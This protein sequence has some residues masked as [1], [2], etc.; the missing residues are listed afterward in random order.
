MSQ[1]ETQKVDEKPAASPVEAANASANSFTAK[2]VKVVLGVQTWTIIG[3]IAIAL[4]LGAL[5]VAFS[6]EEVITALGYVFAQPSDFFT[7]FG[8]SISTFFYSLFVGAIFDPTGSG[9]AALFPITETLTNS[10]PLIL[11][12]LSVGVAFRAGL[13]NIGAQGQLMMGALVG[14]VMGFVLQLPPVIHLLFCMIMAIVGGFIWGA[15]P[16]IL[17]A[18]T[19]ANEVIVTIMLNTVASLL[20]G[21]FMTWPSLIKGT[22][23]SRSKE[24]LETSLYPEILPFI[25]NSRLHFGFIVALLAAVFVWWL[26]ERSTFGFELRAAGANPEAAKT[27]GINVPRV[28]F[29][30]MAIAGALSGLAATGPVLG[31]GGVVTNSVAG[32]YGFDAITVALLGKSKPAGVVGA[33]ILFGALAAA[34]SVMQVN[35]IP[36]DI[37]SITQAMIVLL[38]AASEA[39]HYYNAKKKAHKAVAAEKAKDAKKEVAA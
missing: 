37:V 5:I 38:I 24:L 18:K 1:K 6:D 3:A 10:V 20:L 22:I 25:P 9:L 23:T 11:A 26:L 12:G 2:L 39:F 4:L 29:L 28:T 7:A 19:G 16:G 30:T 35:N 21:W 8:N 36:V 32:S 15:I 17:K 31:T 33:G 34:K 14:G 27:A 13:F